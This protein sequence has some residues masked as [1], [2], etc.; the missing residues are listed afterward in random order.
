MHVFFEWPMASVFIK[1]I[2]VTSKR[3]DGEVVVSIK[4]FGVGIPKAD[5]EK[6]FERFYR[7]GSGLFGV[8]GFGLGL[9]ICH[10]IIKR[11]GGRIWVESEGEE[12]KGSTFYFSLP[13]SNHQ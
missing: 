6:V 1:Q 7:A 10:E 3:A 13:V 2:I 12:G 8:S 5:Q 11:H 9:Y 4:D